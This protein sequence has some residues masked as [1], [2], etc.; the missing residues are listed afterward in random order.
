MA[1][2]TKQRILPDF[3]DHRAYYEA[4]HL[5]FEENLNLTV[6]KYTFNQIIQILMYCNRS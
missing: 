5:D 2:N 6:L 1:E 3:T 4:H